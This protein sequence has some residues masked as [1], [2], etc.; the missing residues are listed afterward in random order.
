MISCGPGPV[1]R[2]KTPL[3]CRSNGRLTSLLLALN[4]QDFHRHSSPQ[5]G[6]EG[7]DSDRGWAFDPRSRSATLYLRSNGLEQPRVER[8]V[9]LRFLLPLLSNIQTGKKPCPHSTR[10]S[11]SGNLL[12]GSKERHQFL[13]PIHTCKARSRVYRSRGDALQHDSGI[14][15]HYRLR[16]AARPVISVEIP[17]SEL[18]TRPVLAGDEYSLDLHFES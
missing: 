15:T 2:E 1:L 12:T 7:L 5:D 18:D 3:A 11:F 17:D 6:E 16:P 13:R 10:S 4:N 14:V 9:R 8:S